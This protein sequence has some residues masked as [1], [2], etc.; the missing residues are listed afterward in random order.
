LLVENFDLNASVTDRDRQ[1]DANGDGFPDFTSV[2]N[3]DGTYAVVQPYIQGQFRLTEKLTLNA[4]LHGQYFSINEQSVI[5]PRASLSYALN[6]KS[7]VNIG[8]GM[9]HQNV[10]APLLFINENVGG[11]LVQTNRNLD[12]IRSDHF[13][14]GYDLRLANKWRS[15]IEVY[16]QSISN[17]AVDRFSSGYSSLT[18]G[19]DFTYSTD[20]TSLVSKGKGTNAGIEFTVEKFFSKGYNVL[21]TSSFFE[22]KYKGSDGVERNSPFNNG[23]VVNALAGKEFKIGKSKKNVFLI[24][25]KVTTAGGRYYTPVNLAAS[26]AAGYEIKDAT[27]PFSKQYDAYL[28]V[29]LK[30]GMKFNSKRKKN[31]HQFYID[32]QNVTGNENVFTLQYNRQTNAVD[33]KNQ[34]GFQPD[35]GYRFNF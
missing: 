9:H 35:F 12:L 21:F 27:Q 25:S 28:R 20:K 24:N 18:E 8:Y 14:L 26:R 33:Q 13:V 31:S 4:G 34:I 30:I 22:S 11:N 15:K 6:E 2:I 1:A 29:D 19:A 17:A 16:Y 23:Y 7:A 10:A 5:E 32:F 3:N